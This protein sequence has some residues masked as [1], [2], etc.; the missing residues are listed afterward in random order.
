MD[1]TVNDLKDV[2]AALASSNFR[3]GLRSTTPKAANTDFEAPIPI[4]LDVVAR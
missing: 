4:T 2:N 3:L 1:L